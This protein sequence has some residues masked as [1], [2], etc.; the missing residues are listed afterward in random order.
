MTMMSQSYFTAGL[1]GAGLGLGV[2]AVIGAAGFCTTPIPV[3]DPGGGGTGLGATL[4]EPVCLGPTPAL[5]YSE[6]PDSSTFDPAL[7]RTSEPASELCFLASPA[8]FFSC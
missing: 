4:S 7:R 5:R 8:C 3:A 1:A 6:G 2:E